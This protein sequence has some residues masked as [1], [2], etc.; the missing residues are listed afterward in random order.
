MTRWL[1]PGPSSQFYAGHYF[2]RWSACRLF[3]LPNFAP[4]IFLFSISFFSLYSSPM[5]SLRFIYVEKRYAC[6]WCWIDTLDLIKRPFLTIFLARFRS[7]YKRHFQPDK[8]NFC[9]ESGL[10]RPYARVSSTD[11]LI[12]AKCFCMRFMRKSNARKVTSDR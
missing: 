1:A 6:K 12:G 4:S 10:R 3:E 8:T 7:D 11:A 9:N 2:S 5:V